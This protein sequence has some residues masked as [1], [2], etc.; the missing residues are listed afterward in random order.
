MHNILH[1]PTSFITDNYIDIN[2]LTFIDF[3]YLIM[4]AQEMS[5]TY[6]KFI[7]GNFNKDTVKC[8]DSSL[9]R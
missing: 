9:P 4:S 7:P 2:R 6:R 5:T 3:D 8:I 1:G